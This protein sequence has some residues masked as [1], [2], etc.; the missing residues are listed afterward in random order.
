M[1]DLVLQHCMQLICVAETT[2][3]LQGRIGPSLTLRTPGCGAQDCSCMAR[4]PWLQADQ[5]C[6]AWPSGF[7]LIRCFWCRC[8]PHLPLNMKQ[9]AYKDLRRSALSVHAQEVASALAV[10]LWHYSGQFPCDELSQVSSRATGHVCTAPD[11]I[12]QCLTLGIHRVFI[13]LVWTVAC[14]ALLLFHILCQ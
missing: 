4:T 1:R 8:F 3:W 5:I 11:A 12:C 14:Q 13:E 9:S 2:N 6:L 7:C 10:D